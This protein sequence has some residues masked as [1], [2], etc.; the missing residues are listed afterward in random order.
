MIEHKLDVSLV[1]PPD[2]ITDPMFINRANETNWMIH[3]LVPFVRRE[4]TPANATW[5][6]NWKCCWT[7]ISAG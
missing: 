4:D 5:D 7:I 1:P 6:K 3:R 2:R